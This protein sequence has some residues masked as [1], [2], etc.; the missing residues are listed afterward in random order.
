MYIPFGS[1][2]GVAAIFIWIVKTGLIATIAL[3][4]ADLVEYLTPRY[5][6]GL[7]T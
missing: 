1:C 5:I 4:F 3:Y 6:V 7:N 2:L